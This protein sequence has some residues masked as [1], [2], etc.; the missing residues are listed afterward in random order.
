[1][2]T[3]L[4]ENAKM[5]ERIVYADYATNDNCWNPYDSY[6]EICV[7]CGCCS[8]DK[9][10]RYKARYKLCQRMIEKQLSFD[11]WCEEPEI[12][13]LQQENIK[14]NLKYFRRLS[15]YYKKKLEGLKNGE[16]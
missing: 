15:R 1:M 5:A 11:G 13:A 8:K 6:G 4:R 12:R 3:A 2:I 16:T 14:L 7:G 9:A 10:T